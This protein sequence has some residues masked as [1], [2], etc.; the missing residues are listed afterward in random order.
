[1]LVGPSGIGKTFLLDKLKRHPALRNTLGPFVPLVFPQLASDD[2]L[3]YCTACLRSTLWSAEPEI[4]YQESFANHYSLPTLLELEHRLRENT[5]RG[6]RAVL[7]VDDAE[8]IDDPKVLRL[9]KSLLSIEQDGKPC[10]SLVFLGEETTVNAFEMIPS[11]EQRIEA[12]CFLEPF[13]E[14]ETQRY[15]EGRLETAGTFRDIFEPDAVFLIH[16]L[17]Q[18]IPRQINRLCDLALLVGFAQKVTQIEPPLVESLF[19]DLVAV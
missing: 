10:L 4:R 7:M 1:M 2:L 13:S 6:S 11:L 16:E 14:S 17:S 8:M 9:F 3:A 19:E 12:K 18:G 15:V 5:K